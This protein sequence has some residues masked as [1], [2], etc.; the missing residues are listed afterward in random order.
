MSDIGKMG[1]RASGPI[2]FPVPGSKGGDS[3]SLSEGSTLTH[4][5]GNCCS[6]SKNFEDLST[7][8]LLTI[9]KVKPPF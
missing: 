5:E 4:A 6:E 9:R 3:G 8:T 1:A 2:G 7:E